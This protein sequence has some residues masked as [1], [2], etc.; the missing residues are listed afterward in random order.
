MVHNLSG[1]PSES[2]AS[3]VGGVACSI[4]GVA[5]IG[6]GL[7]ERICDDGGID[8]VPSGFARKHGED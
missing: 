7:M 8:E 2:M 5:C 4:A 6:Q 1:A 3:S